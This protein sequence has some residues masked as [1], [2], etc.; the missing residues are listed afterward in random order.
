MDSK[1]NQH[2]TA[3]TGVN[4]NKKDNQAKMNAVTDLR[5]MAMHASSMFTGMSVVGGSADGAPPFMKILQNRTA[6]YVEDVRESP[7]GD[8]DKVRDAEELVA[9]AE[10]STH[11]WFVLE[12]GLLFNKDGK[13]KYPIDEL[14]R[15]A[16]P[17]NA[18]NVRLL[19]CARLRQQLYLSY[20]SHLSVL[21]NHLGVEVAPLGLILAFG[22]CR[23][24]PDA[25]TLLQR[26]RARVA[27][28][29]S[30]LQCE[31]GVYTRHDYVGP[32]YACVWYGHCAWALHVKCNLTLS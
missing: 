27:G 18:S 1:H 7:T 22:A 14:S 8:D 26:Y 16:N 19:N 12:A 17:A 13:G 21:C 31:L 5:N 2:G 3:E 32:H 11:L 15:C 20:A 4:S 9:G 6:T 23:T 24:F 30:S 29:E 25:I 10:T 28:R